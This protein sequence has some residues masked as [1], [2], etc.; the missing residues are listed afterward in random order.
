MKK[1]IFF[2]TLLLFAVFNL[3]AIGEDTITYRSKRYLD[4]SDFKMSPNSN[5]S[6]KVKLDLTITTF[7][8]KVN[9]LWGTVTVE[10]YAGIRRDLS[11]VKPQYK[12]QQ[13]LNYIQLKYEIANYFAIKTEKEIN[14]KKINA[15][16]TKKISK[17]IESHIN[18]MNSTFEEYDIETDFG[19]N[20]EIVNQWKVKLKNGEI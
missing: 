13:L 3:K 14:R 2:S 6:L 11:W 1:K 8:K 19:I 4:W 12:S 18:A 10:S 15:A 20:T 7:N 5:S 9:V 16:S 17:I